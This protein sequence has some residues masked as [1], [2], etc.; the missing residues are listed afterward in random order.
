M[1]SKIFPI[2]N[3]NFARLFCNT[4]NKTIYVSYSDK[5]SKKFVFKEINIILTKYIK[6]RCNLI[7]HLKLM[8]HLLY[9]EKKIMYKTIFLHFKDEI[10]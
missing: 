7:D 6:K 9:Y 5:I 10:L 3:V 4:N 1:N 8:N 2:K